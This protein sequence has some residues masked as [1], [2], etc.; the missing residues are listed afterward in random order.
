V[1]AVSAAYGRD[2]E[3]C[4]RQIEATIVKARRRGTELVV[5]PEAALGGYLWE[6]AV[7]GK[8]RSGVVDRVDAGPRCRPRSS[9]PGPPLLHRDGPEIAHLIAAAGPTV[10]CVGYSELGP[11]GPYASAVCLNGDGVLGHHRKVHVPP[12]EQSTYV[13]GDGFAVFETPLGR[14][15]MLICYDKVFPEAARELSLDGAGIIASLSA[16]PVCRHNPASYVGR[17]RQVRQFNL[18]D[19]ARAV[20]NQVV[21]VSANQTGRFGRL[22]FAGQSKIVDPDGKVLA[23]TGAR[24]GLATARVDLKHVV[25]TAR[26]ELSHLGARVPAAYRIPTS[27]GVEPIAAPGGHVAAMA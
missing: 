25:S 2:L 20:E 23:A 9:V 19:Q 5:F 21:W 15:G 16:W 24:S 22:R 14:M 27:A 10:V 3:Q 11:R 17:D 4:L 1:A 26:S 8:E 13:P 18:L 7:A 12:G 6:P